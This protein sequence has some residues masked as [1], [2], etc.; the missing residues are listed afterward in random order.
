MLKWIYNLWRYFWITVFSVL[1]LL[2]FLLGIALLLLQFESVQNRIALEIKSSFDEQYYG[3]ISFGK[4]QGTLPV[5]LRLSDV[6]IVYNETDSDDLI[7]LSDTVLAARDIYLRLDLRQSLFNRFTISTASIDHPLINLNRTSDGENLTIARAFERRY[8]V[9]GARE[10]SGDGFD[11]NQL[12]R[13][14]LQELN[15]SNGIITGN[16]LHTFLDDDASI[17]LPKSFIIEDITLRLSLELSAEEQFLGFREFSGKTSSFD[18]EEFLFRGQVYA[19]DRFFELNRFSLRTAKSNLRFTAAFEGVDIAKADLIGQMKESTLNF[20]IDESSVLTNEFSDL[21]PDIPILEQPV[22]ID[23]RTV[24]NEENLQLSRLDLRYGKSTVMIYGEASDL[25]GELDYDLVLDF[26]NLHYD[27]MAILF[28]EQQ[29]LFPEMGLF[30]LRGDANGSRFHVKSDV[31]IT[32]DTGDIEFS[33]EI[34][35]REKLYYLV[36]GEIDNL[37]F[38]QMPG[39]ALGDSRL[40]SAFRLEGAGDD[41]EDATASLFIQIRDSKINDFDLNELDL[42]AVLDDG[43]LEPDLTIRQTG[44]SRLR[45][46][47]WIDF[48]QKEPS[49]NLEGNTVEFN[50]A[51]LVPDGSVKEGRVNTTFTLNATGSE[52]DNYSGE[53]FL[54]IY[55][56]DYGDEY[57]EEHEFFAFLDKPNSQGRSLRIGGTML[58]AEISGSVVPTRIIETTRYWI[59]EISQRISETSVYDIA[60]SELLPPA[61]VN[62]DLL[63]NELTIRARIDDLSLINKIFPGFPE[64]TTISN[65][66]ATLRSNRETFNIETQLYSDFIE[67]DVLQLDSLVVRANSSYHR[68]RAT[69]FFEGNFEVLFASLDAAGQQFRNADLYVDAYDEALVLQRFKTIIGDDVELG[70]MLSAVF[71]DRDVDIRIMDFYVGDE[72]Y[73]WQNIEQTPIRID[74][75]GRVHVNRLEFGNL[76]ER[77]II[78]GTFSESPEDSVSYL[79]SGIELERISSLI[80]GRVNFSGVLDGTFFTRSIRTDPNFMGDIQVEALRLDNRLVGDVGFRS[81]FD[82]E[83]ERFDTRLTIR[84]DSERYQTYLQRNEDIGQDII[85]E[86]FIN[87]LQ[88]AGDAEDA[89][90]ASFDVTMNE[91]DLW[92]LPLIVDGVFEQVEGRARGEGVLKLRRDGLH[93][94]SS[95]DIIDVNVVPV[96][97]LTTL[98]L[99]GNLDLNSEN[100]VTLNNISVRDSNGGT[101]TLRGNID[102]ELF[103]GG[104]V[105]DLALDMNSLTF[106]NNRAGP[107]IPFYGRG[108]G[109]GTVR[110]MG[111]NDQPFISTPTPV[112]LSSNSVFSIPVSTDQSVEGGT[113]F[114]QFVDDFS[115]IIDL[116]ALGNNNGR[117]GSTNG[118]IRISDNADLTFMEKF[119]MDLQFQADDNMLVRIIFDDVTSEILSARGTGRIRLA[120]QDE[121]FQVFGRF[122]VA[123]GDYL[124]V[125]GDIFTRRFSIREGGTISWEGDP[126]NARIDVSATY[127]ARPNINVLRPGQADDTPQRTPVDLIL[128]ITG[129]LDSIENDFFFEFPTGTDISQSATILAIINDEDEKL[130]QAT[131][132]LL[133]GNFVPRDTQLNDLFGSQFGAQ[134]L[135]TLLS[136]QISNILNSNISNLDIDLNMTGFE[137]A[138]LGIAL[139]LFD[140]RLTLRR[141]GT[142]TGPNSNLGDFDVTYRINRYFS[143]EAFMRRESLLPSAVSVGQTQTNEIYGVGVEARVQFNTW[144]EL[145]DRIWGSVNKLF[146]SHQK[147]EEEPDMA[148]SD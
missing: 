134:G 136:S 36:E 129:T 126:V 140:D 28:P 80:N 68:G 116:N 109:T 108:V 79:F 20:R 2:S 74:D 122:D 95:F 26:I 65:L 37:R 138:D 52:L 44:D 133:S 23:L 14:D 3:E 72:A 53:V 135:S 55:D 4:V 29:A 88:N 22:E 56:S 103:G 66:D 110:L 42:N 71:S 147:K 6:A 99:D 33:G 46:Y 123:G 60:D 76:Q 107:E 84:T 63:E 145:R 148:S 12:P 40:N 54:N 13:L 69:D 58:E 73:T 62:E 27:D 141:E 91:I 57:I 82:A 7:I 45:A 21:F 130:L 24:I 30:T 93:Y 100:G 124:F 70:A 87:T 34:D 89:L 127:R 114:I 144:G 75:S 137:E 85:V 94:D 118:G 1:M 59:S 35:W 31:S 48:M 41:I 86:G 128:Q 98:N 39:L 18:F 146:G 111:T 120:L 50:P 117:N 119:E 32:S 77:I 38:E 9:S 102:F 61:E 142:V 101:G 104:T 115:Q 67:L 64:I 81:R 15:I 112:Y 83:N 19:D 5:D 92:V 11:T 96:F 8:S 43:F 121:V 125:G 47:G 131:S 10:T 105:F 132:I 51:R 90:F 17:K 113:R 97:L 139:R 106:L 25:A 143:V 49:I 16:N 78:D